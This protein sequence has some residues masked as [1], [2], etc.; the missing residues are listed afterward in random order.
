M[1]KYFAGAALLLAALTGQ[2]H[3]A[4]TLNWKAL[5]DEAVSLLS[6]YVQID[7]TNPPGN[8]MKAAQF[9][10]AIFDK[11]GIENR[12]IESA[13]GR[14]NFYARLPGDGSKKAL[15]LM[16]H[17]DVVPA[18]SRLWKE[19]AFSGVVKDGA[20]WGRGAID[21]KGGGV[22]GLMTVVGLKRQN[23]ALKGDV[24]LLG[25]ADEEAGGV[26][27]AGFLV[28][29]HADLFK[30]VGVVLNEGGS[31]RV[32]EK[33]TARVYSVGVSEK[34]PLWLKLT[35]VGAPGHA[36]SPGPNQAVLRLIG[37]LQRVASYQTPI[38]V[39]PE[40]QKFYA[41]SAATA[42]QPWRE[43]YRDL[44]KSL[45]DPAVLAEFVKDRS[46]NARVRNTISI[47]GLKG[48][49]KIN[50]IPAFAAAEIDVRLLPG[51]DP[52][53]FIADLRKVIGDDSIK[54]E[55][56]LSRNAAKTPHSPEAMKVI[57][58]YANATDPGTPVIESMGSGFTDCHFFREKAIPCLGFLPNRASSVNE[59]MVHGID[60][61][62][63][64]ESL[65][66][67]VRAMYEIVRKLVVE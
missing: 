62:M 50:V 65:K 36:A 4:E 57:T 23:T 25:T 41:D 12:V 22:L 66:S 59:G 45:E 67:G 61:R 13:P 46:N 42:P 58:D 31:I 55:I 28:E 48:S 30:N 3:S 32:D 19:T 7:T 18:E 6:R 35:A 17:M 5:E 37:A 16:H 33:G 15:V 14:A 8:E 27:G 24:I 21:N 43:R 29:N 2:A 9:L 44:R 1:K 52:Q 39:V 11:E 20:V 60:E 63:S 54:V 47:T 49:D 10:K 38:K 51:E 56:M 34:V 26:F 64:V 40:V 53:A